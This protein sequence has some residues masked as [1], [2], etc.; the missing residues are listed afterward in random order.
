MKKNI[1]KD[2]RTIC[3][4]CFFLRVII[5]NSLSTLIRIHIR[6]IWIQV[7]DTNIQKFFS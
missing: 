6:K 5:I 4:N 2:K 7:F 1:E 3:N